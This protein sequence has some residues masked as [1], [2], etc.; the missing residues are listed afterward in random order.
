MSFNVRVMLRLDLAAEPV[1]F[2]VYTDVLSV[3]K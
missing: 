2:A 1:L 3:H